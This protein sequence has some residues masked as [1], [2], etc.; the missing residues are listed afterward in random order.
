MTMWRWAKFLVLHG[1]VILCFSSCGKPISAP[2]LPEP[3]PMKKVVGDAVF[4]SQCPY[5]YVSQPRTHKLG[6]WDCP[7]VLE[8]LELSSPP[9]PLLFQADCYKKTLSIRTQDRKFDSFWEVMPD[10]SFD[11]L[12]PGGSVGIQDDGAGGRCVSYVLLEVWGKL[13]CNDR[14]RVS[15]EVDII[16]W[17]GKGKSP[18]VSTVPIHG[19]F[20]GESTTSSS[21]LRPC[22]LPPGCYLHTF[23]E[24]KQCE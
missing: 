15:I 5:G 22:Q 7:V 3:N 1:F 23:G 18:A 24:V 10:G 9:Q 4:L 11:L 2:Q 6:L 12:L 21:R 8:Q 20:A 17:L 13:K 14:D 16:W 19:T